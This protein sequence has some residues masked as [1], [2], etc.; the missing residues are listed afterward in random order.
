[1]I[2]K[3]RKVSG[4]VMKTGRNKRQYTVRRKKPTV[5]TVKSI[6]KREVAKQCETKSIYVYTPTTLTQNVVAYTQLFKPV[7]GT[8]DTQRIGDAINLVGLSIKYGFET[9]AGNVGGLRIMIVR[10]RLNGATIAD[11][12]MFRSERGGVNNAMYVSP[13]NTDKVSVIYDKKINVQC[14]GLA[15]VRSVYTG[16]IYINLK[17]QK[18]LFDAQNSTDGKYYNYYIAFL[19]QVPALATGVATGSIG[20]HRVEY[21]KDP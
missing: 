6:V 11:A 13:L 4:F 14:S 8:N 10:T 2:Y 5:A 20:I 21:F 3:G 18:H 17:N 15:T 16:S 7:Q 9:I 1:M 12:D 19:G